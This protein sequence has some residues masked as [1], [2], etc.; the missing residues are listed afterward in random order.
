[1]RFDSPFGDCQSESCASG[2]ACTPFVNPIEAV[3]DT[4]G[5]IFWDPGPLIFDHDSDQSRPIRSAFAI[6][7]H[8]PEWC[9]RRE[10][11]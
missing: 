2:V 3:E 6:L 9:S 10:N 7:S 1:M 11:I 4:F 5:L 8:S